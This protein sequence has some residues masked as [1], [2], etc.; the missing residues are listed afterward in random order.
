MAGSTIVDDVCGLVA[1]IKAMGPPRDRRLYIPRSWMEAL[2]DS[3][4]TRAEEFFR[5]LPDPVDTGEMKGENDML[6]PIVFKEKVVCAEYGTTTLYFSTSKEMLNGKYP[7]AQSMMISVEYP[8]ATPEARFASVMF[9]P[10][11]DGESYDWFDADLRYKDIAKLI[12]YGEW[13]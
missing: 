9:S 6:L 11:K 8:T 13:A 10:T 1:H 12:D 7:D 4:Y 5:L 2:K 3:G